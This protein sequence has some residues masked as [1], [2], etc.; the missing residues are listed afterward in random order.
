MSIQLLGVA[1]TQTIR[2]RYSKI[3]FTPRSLDH[4]LFQEEARIEVFT[5]IRALG[6]SCK[7][8]FR[9]DRMSLSIMKVRSDDDNQS[10]LSS[11]MT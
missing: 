2:F 8:V 9:L 3:N 1:M 5:I 7:I 6:L 10:W 4:V 11:H